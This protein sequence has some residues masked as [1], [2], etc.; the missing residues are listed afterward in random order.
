MIEDYSN[1]AP[2]VAGYS[3]VFE[4]FYKLHLKLHPNNYYAKDI[5]LKLGFPSIHK[6]KK[7]ILEYKPDVV[8]LRERNLY[9]IVCNFI[10][11]KYG[12]KTILYNQSPLWAKEGYFKHDLAH[13]VVN[14]L[15]PNCRITPVNQVGIDMGGKVRDKNTYFAPFVM[16]T[17]CKPADKV[18][19]QKGNVNIL[20]IGKINIILIR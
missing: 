15:T 6:I 2:I 16:Q 3:P 8:I 13:R 10:C 5:N 12:I 17:H 1:V 7:L 11:K 4:S 9:T 14:S 18:Y 19:F 20:E